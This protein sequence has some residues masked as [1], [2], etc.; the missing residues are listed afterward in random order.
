MSRNVIEMNQTIFTRFDEVCSANGFNLKNK[1]K[2]R[3][4]A[5][6]TIDKNFS[7]NAELNNVFFQHTER[8]AFVFRHDGHLYFGFVGFRFLDEL[9]EYLEF[10]KIDLTPGML[11]FLAHTKC[12]PHLPSEE[13]LR[14]VLDIGFMGGPDAYEGHDFQQVSRLFPSINIFESQNFDLANVSASIFKFCLIEKQRDMSLLNDSLAERIVEI[15]DLEIEELPH[16]TMARSLFD[17]DPG[18]FFLALYRCIE[19]LYSA[20]VCKNIASE[21]DFKGD[22][23]EVSILLERQLSWRPNEK[24]SLENLFSSLDEETLSN[25]IGAISTEQVAITASSAATRVY[26]LRNNLVHFRPATQTL[27][28]TKDIKWTELFDGLLK[29]IRQIYQN[30]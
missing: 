6:S 30:I 15:L 12:I 20:K 5:S 14:D 27:A 2:P 23:K 13:L 21:F 8:Q 7:A 29:A 24:G 28:D 17:A 25:I 4:I 10:Q 9:N 3:Y 19:A 11:T 26:N 16:E 1:N 18:S 22:W